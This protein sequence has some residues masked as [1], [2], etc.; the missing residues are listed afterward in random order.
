MNSLRRQFTSKDHGPLVQF[1]KYAI[2]GVVATIVHVSVFYLMAL[3]FIPALTPDDP[4]SLIVDIP[5]HDLTDS[6][7]SLHA[8]LDNFIAFMISNSVV[9][10]INI[11]WVFEAGKHSRCKEIV[12]FFAVSGLSVLIGTGL[13]TLLINS[14]GLDTSYAFFIN[15]GVCLMINYAARKFFIF[16]N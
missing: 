5:P 3:K 16:K 7:R 12:M 9:Y 14:L 1:C 6:V 2:A 8:A 4:I 15:A 11:F 13:Q 10:L